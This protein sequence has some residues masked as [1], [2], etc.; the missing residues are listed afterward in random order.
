M[1]NGL[2]GR[3]RAPTPLRSCSPPPDLL[4]LTQQHPEKGTCK[5]TACHR[6]VIV[7]TLPT[8]A[9]PGV[10]SSPKREKPAEKCADMALPFRTEASGRQSKGLPWCGQA[11]VV[12]LYLPLFLAVDKVVRGWM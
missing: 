9:L 1:L 11:I 2:G 5:Q 4:E 7:T 12:S 6:G 3:S 8:S 10:G